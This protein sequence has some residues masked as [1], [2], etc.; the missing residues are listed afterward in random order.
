MRHY[1]VAALFLLSA[2]LSIAPVGAGEGLTEALDT[3]VA[4]GVEDWEVPGLAMAVVKDGDL[5]FAKGYGVRELGAEG[6]VDEHTLFAIGSTTKAITAASVALS[7]D[8]GKVG[9]DDPVTQ[10]LPGFRLSDP[11]VTREVTVRDLLT[12]R[13]GLGNA[14]QLWYGKDRDR[15][16][17]LA[18]V[19]LI[20]SAYSLRDGF[21]YQN[22][23]YLVAGRLAGAVAGSTWEE[24]VTA[25]I[26]A[27]LGMNRTVP[28][29]ADAAAME[30]VARPHDRIDDVV[31]VID[32][33]TADSVGPAGTVWSSVADM[34][35]WLRMLLA[36]GAWGEKR[37][38][39]EEAVGELLEPQT[40][41]DLS[42]FYPAV[43]LID[44]H[45]TTYGLGWFQLDYQGRAVSF[46]T[47]SIDGMAAIVGLVPDEDLGI[48]VLEN[49]DHAELRHALLWKAIDLWGGRSD[50]RDWSAEL[51]RIYADR[52]AEGAA[53]EKERDE[54][55]ATGTRPAA[56]LERY[57]G[58]YVHP[59]YDGVEVTH[60]DGRL[61][62]EAGPRLGGELEH[63]HYE[64]FV[65]RFDRRWQGQA[66][67]NFSFDLSGRPS[68]LELMGNT[69]E[70]ASEN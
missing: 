50:G 8:E 37:I 12:H 68:Q 58:S 65:V 47:G 25:R 42:A 40:L 43:E 15:D 57:A 52:A 2:L 3:Y 13:A 23:M 34:S 5:V 36:E 17:I 56:P 29:I 62:L 51:E 32:N 46:H 63:W 59:I 26:F 4:Q 45:W 39:S 35:R 70:R 67:I 30:N 61:R 1:L 24:L 11:Y 60:A 38:L 64:T 10:H 33:E 21:I 6:A 22:I 54:A 9:W 66:P 48:V 41:L 27:P 44:P 53:R 7:V 49:L 16:A 31:T 69:Y 19:P 18:K 28:N 14:D 55:R 20:E